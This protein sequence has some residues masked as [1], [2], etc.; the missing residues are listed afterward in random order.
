MGGGRL[1]F[2]KGAPEK[3][4]SFCQTETGKWT[5]LYY[6]WLICISSPNMF[7]EHLTYES[8]CLLIIANRMN[9]LHA[10]LNTKI[11]I[12]F[13]TSY[14]SHPD[15]WHYHSPTS[16]I[17][18]SF[19]ICFSHSVLLFWQLLTQSPITLTAHALIF[20]LLD[21]FSCWWIDLSSSHFYP[22]PTFILWLEWVFHHQI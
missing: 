13:L 17:W 18:G 4:A 16:P 7:T 11:K 2:M 3:V 15:E 6:S 10:I 5:D 21:H 12:I 20:P 22:D 14:I 8:N 9:H 19:Q 1:V